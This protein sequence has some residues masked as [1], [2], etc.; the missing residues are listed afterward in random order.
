M[1]SST[2]KEVECTTIDGTVIRGWFYAVPGPAPTLIM[3]HGFNC[4]KEMTLPDA[5]EWFQRRGYNVLLYDARSVG[6]S[7][8]LPR[9]QLDVLQM[10][11]DLSDIVTFVATLPTVDPRS[12]LLWGMSFGGTVS[13]CSAAVDHRPRALVM[14]CPLFSFV[15]PNRRGATFARVI[16]DRVSQMGG[17]EPLSFPPFNSKGENV[18]GFGGAGGPGGLEAYNLMRAAA[19][20]GPPGFRDRIALQTFHKLALARPMELLDMVD[21]RMSVLMVVP[22]LDDISSP[23]EQKAAFEKLST[24]K[25]QLHVARGAGHLSVMTGEGSEELL[26]VMDGFFRDA[27]KNDVR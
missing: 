25:K 26:E 13:G 4:V 21:E 16:Q 20:R 15:R 19:E 18:A 2:Y 27:L 11:E 7:D 17:N 1:G 8:G 3:S 5:A 14:V 9:N 12:I 6:A 10:A 23:Q 24:P 22:E